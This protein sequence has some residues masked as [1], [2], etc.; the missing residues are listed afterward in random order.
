M[1]RMEIPWNFHGLRAFHHAFSTR[2]PVAFEELFCVTDFT[3]VCR[4]FSWFAVV[5]F[6]FVAIFMLVSNHS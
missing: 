6:L 1:E 3:K 2:V 4:G 5:V